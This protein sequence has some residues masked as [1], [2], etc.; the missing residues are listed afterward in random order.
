MLLAFIAFILFVFRV[1]HL[2]GDGAKFQIFLYFKVHPRYRK[3]SKFLFDV[4]NMF[5]IWFASPKISLLLGQNFCFDFCNGNWGYCRRLFTIQVLFLVF[6]YWYNQ[7]I[8][9][10]SSFESVGYNITMKFVYHKD[11][12]FFIV[13]INLFHINKLTNV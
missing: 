13:H 9:R 11:I 2:G 8:A 1:S 12:A 3:I 7:I 10:P 4:L 6:F 5:S